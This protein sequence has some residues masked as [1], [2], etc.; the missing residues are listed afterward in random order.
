MKDLNHFDSDQIPDAVKAKYSR[1]ESILAEMKKVVVA[2]SGGVDSS[3]LLKAAHD[4]LGSD[5]LAVMLSSEVIS[6]R[7]LKDA[8]ELAEDMGISMTVL[9]HKAL[10]NPKFVKNTPLRCYYCKKD[11][12]TE[13]KKFALKQEIF[14]VVDGSNYE[15]AEDYRPG[16]KALKEL[17]IRSPLEEAGFLK[18]EIRLLSRELGLPT[19]NKPAMACLASRFP[20]HT[21][22]DEKS[23]KKV[24]CAEEYLRDLGFTQV[25]VRHHGSVARIEILEEQFDLIITDESRGKI[26]EFVKKLGYSYVTL[27]LQGYRMGSL[28]EEIKI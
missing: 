6:A 15:D 14:H 28:N 5:V 7:E 8:E 17:G 23:L 9:Q 3:F 2:Y 25:R 10:N 27:D 12:F 20:Y 19:W 13:I 22:I 1:L 16:A 26:V 24:A 18:K 21:E 4:V 11:I